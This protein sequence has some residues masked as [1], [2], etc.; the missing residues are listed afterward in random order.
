MTRALTLSAL[1]IYP[2][3][4][5]AGISLESAEVDTF[6]L[7]YD[8]RWMW[9]REDGRFITQR[10]HRQLALIRTSL[11]DGFLVL[12]AP[13]QGSLH[14]PLGVLDEPEP[15]GER[16]PVGIWV[17]EVR[18]V[19]ASPEAHEWISAF[20]HEPIRMVY[21]PRDEV[22]ATDPTYAEGY[23][24]GFADG[25]PFLL[26]TEAS[27]DD[28]NGRLDE[29]VPMD[30][31][32]ANLVVSGAEPW[33][34]DGWGPLTVDGVPFLGVKPC[35]RCKVT[36]V[37][38]E[39]GE[40]GVEPLRTLAEFRRIDGRVVFGRNLVQRGGGVIRVGGEVVVGE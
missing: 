13:G 15:P 40:Q 8:R 37:N 3:K 2:V 16:L 36:T 9:V 27:L 24:V 26:T 1:H 4:G 38:Q 17:D 20:L 30:R 23:R 28:L 10:S 34:E 29:P 12:A 32:R 19:T 25:Y 14:L 6:G 39:T 22:R 11:E 7:R 5:A 21:I 31:F 18:A 33:E 35:G